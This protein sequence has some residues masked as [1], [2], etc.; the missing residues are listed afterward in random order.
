[1]HNHGRKGGFILSP[2]IGE[3]EMEKAESGKATLVPRVN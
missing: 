2:D 3:R 1:M